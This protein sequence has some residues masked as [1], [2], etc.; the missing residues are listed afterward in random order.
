M[1][2]DHGMEFNGISGNKY[3]ATERN[4]DN[5]TIYPDQKCYFPQPEIQP[6]GVRNVSDC[7]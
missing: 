7:K 2:L 6:S 4:F 3:V 5:G 1:E